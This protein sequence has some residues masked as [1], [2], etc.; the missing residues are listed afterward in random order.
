MSFMDEEILKEA[1]KIAEAREKMESRK[2]MEEESESSIYDEQV[3]IMGKP[4]R[5]ERRTIEEIG[6]SIMMPT[7]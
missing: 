6:I 4:V 3:M 1:R 7:I 5:F 2:N